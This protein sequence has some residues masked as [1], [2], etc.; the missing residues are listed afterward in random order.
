MKHLYLLLTL[1]ALCSS[2]K[3]YS[4]ETFPTE[5][6]LKGTVTDFN[7]QPIKGASVYVDSAKTRTTTNR[8][9]IFKINIKPETELLTVF[10]DDYGIVSIEF[11]GEKELSFKYPQNAKPISE[12]NLSLLGFVVSVSGKQDA[13]NY[14][15]YATVYDILKAKFRQVR[16][17]GTKITIAKGPNTYSGNSDPLIVVNGVP[18]TNLTSIP[19]SEIKS[20]QVIQA[21]SEAAEYGLRGVNGVL[22]IILKK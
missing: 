14:A 7:N 21:G 2:P 18:T 11:N 12:E 16:V 4:Q 6:S 15:D 13:N 17:N 20:I 5:V 19:T 3:M 1:L 22:V 9:G 8:K 10:S